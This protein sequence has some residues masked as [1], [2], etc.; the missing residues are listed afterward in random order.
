MHRWKRWIAPVAALTAT[1]VIA[2]CSS[3]SCSSSSA[4]SSSGRASATGSATTAA[5]SGVAKA[6]AMVTQLSGVTTK[7]PVPT[8]PVSGVSALKGKTVYYIPLVAA[9]PGFVVTAAAMKTRARQGRTEAAGLQRPGQPERDRRLRRAGHRR[10]RGRASSLT[11]S[12][13]AWP[14]TRSTRPR[15]R[16]SRS[17]S[18][19]SSRPPEH[20]QQRHG[21]P[22]CP[23]WSTSPARSP[24][25]PSPTRRAAA[26][27]II[28]QEVDSPSSIAVRDQLAGDLQAV[29]PRLQDHGQED[30]RVHQLPARLGH[31]LQPAGQ[32]ERDLL[33]HRVRGQPP[34]DHPGHPAVEQDRAS[35]L[36]VAGGSM[37]GLGLLKSG[38][39]VSRPSSRWTR[40]TPGGR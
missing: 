17:S 33:L 15:P 11:P 9:I 6:D 35:S 8:T 32:P 25:G 19:T 3:S 5:S 14:R 39:S 36:S 30:H 20:G 28:A 10:G 13:T 2:G 7:Y 31:Q 24:G 34:A 38:S 29:L 16:A 26:N 21:R 4:P 37:D 27:A 18:P 1:A 40:R 12:P 23:A 22:T